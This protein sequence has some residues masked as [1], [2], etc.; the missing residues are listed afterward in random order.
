MGLPA[1]LSNIG[2]AEEMVENGDNGYVY[3]PGDV[4]ALTACI[5]KL[6]D[7][8][9]LEKLSL[10]ARKIVAEK[11]SA[12]IMAKRYDEIIKNG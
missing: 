12:Q 11:F 3:P 1:V 6:T 4:E 2:G 5:K 9:T 8:A 7:E 10:A